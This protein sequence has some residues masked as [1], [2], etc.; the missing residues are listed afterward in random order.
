MS[1]QLSDFSADWEKPQAAVSRFMR[2]D[3]GSLLGTLLRTSLWGPYF[4]LWGSCKHTVV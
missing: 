3:I 1:Q 4:H 2:L